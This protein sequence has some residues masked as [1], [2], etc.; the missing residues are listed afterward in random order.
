M[1][2][3]HWY[4]IGYGT[5]HEN[6]NTSS[7]REISGHPISLFIVIITRV[8]LLPFVTKN[9]LK[10]ILMYQLFTLTLEVEVEI[11]NKVLYVCLV[12]SFTDIKLY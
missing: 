10:W 5:N 12:T 9:L 8:K 2:I 11:I 1:G 4:Y 7:I 3:T 6:V